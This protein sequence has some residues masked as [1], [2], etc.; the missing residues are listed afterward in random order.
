MELMHT[1]G[2]EGFD[3]TPSKR[4]SRL[5][6]LSSEPDGALLR[7]SAFRFRLIISYNQSI[8]YS[9]TKIKLPEG[10]LMWCTST[11]GSHYG[12]QLHNVH[13]WRLTNFSLYCS[14]KASGLFPPGQFDILWL[15]VLTIKKHLPDLTDLPAL[16]VGITGGE[17]VICFH[18]F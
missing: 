14:F 12:K 13:R 3:V 15:T 7:T 17:E 18:S 11:T 16:S 10:A 8:R 5:P 6:V 2:P 4:E 1:W 9:I